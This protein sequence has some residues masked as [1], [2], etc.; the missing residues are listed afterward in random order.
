MEKIKGKVRGNRK[1]TGNGNESEIKLRKLGADA[2]R[3]GFYFFS[4][5]CLAHVNIYGPVIIP[6]N[7]LFQ[8]LLHGYSS[9]IDNVETL[10]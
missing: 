4:S 1:L 8:L 9:K 3:R 2:E 6:M 10:T 7:N 5:F